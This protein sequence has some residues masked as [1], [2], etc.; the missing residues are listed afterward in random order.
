MERGKGDSCAQGTQ[1]S[2]N[3]R[4]VHKG[5]TREIQFAN[6]ASRHQDTRSIRVVEP[7]VIV[8]P[9]L[10][11]VSCPVANTGIR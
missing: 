7:S 9:L 6:L 3:A 2:R 8:A 4:H 11:A 10:T 1:E 5:I